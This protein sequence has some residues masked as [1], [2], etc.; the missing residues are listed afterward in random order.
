MTRNCAQQPFRTFHTAAIGL[1]VL[2][3]KSLTMTS[4]TG[5]TDGRQ[6][7][8]RPSCESHAGIIWSLYQSVAF[9]RFQ[10]AFGFPDWH[11]SMY[12]KMSAACSREGLFVLWCCVCVVELR[13]LHSEKPR[14]SVT[15]WSNYKTTASTCH[16]LEITNS[17]ALQGLVIIGN[18]AWNLMEFEQSMFAIMFAYASKP[19]DD[20]WAWWS[21]CCCVKPS[22]LPWASWV[23]S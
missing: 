19:P 17:E 14:A 2:R 11:V 6:K 4:M 7:C 1:L 22:A 12:V 18:S 23:D 15:F 8:Q 3:S 13:H 20:A 9:Q 16:A 5:M 21:W 10:E